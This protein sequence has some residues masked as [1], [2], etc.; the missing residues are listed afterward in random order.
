M[1]LTILVEGKPLSSNKVELIDINAT[2]LLKARSASVGGQFLHLIDLSAK[3]K[4]IDAD[5]N[6]HN[7]PY[8]VIANASSTVLN[9]LESMEGELLAKLK[10]ESIET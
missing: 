6:K 1:A 2:D 7:I 4:L 8:E 5:G 3:T 10:A 9:Q